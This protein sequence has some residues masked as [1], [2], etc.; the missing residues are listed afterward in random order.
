[1]LTN[2]LIILAVIVVGFVVIVGLRPSDFSVSRSAAIGAPPDAVFPQVNNLHNWEAWS[3]WAKIDPTAKSTYE[4]PPAGVGAVFGWSGNNK[5]GEGRMT[6]IESR[7]NE[8]VR[9]KLD[10]LRPFKGTNTAEFS[11]KS[12]RN[13]TQVTWTTTG[14]YGFIPKVFGLFIN[15]DKMMGDQFEKGLAQLN[16]V[17][18]SLAAV[19]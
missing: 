7:P 16:S 6:I 5:I 18:T 4:G 19:K 2:I 12:E 8:L 10:F 3:P 13:Q 11:F 1:M 15:C 17:V 14:R 9:F